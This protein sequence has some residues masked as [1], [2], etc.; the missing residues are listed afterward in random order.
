M[1]ESQRDTFMRYGDLLSAAADKCLVA[2]SALINHKH[3]AN[4]SW[5]SMIES[6]AEQEHSLALTIKEYCSRGPE[7]ILDTRT[8]YKKQEEPI[9]EPASLGAAL[10]RLNDTNDEVAS[11]LGQQA[12][13][14][15]GA[16][17]GEEVRQLGDKVEAIGRKI[18]MIRLTARDA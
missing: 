4:S 8:Q 15:E 3:E 11:I 17:I 12:E 13:K 2:E 6:V 5:Q 1:T 18:S 16:E 14:F 7:K 9:P 10:S